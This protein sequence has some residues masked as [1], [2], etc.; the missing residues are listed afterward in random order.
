MIYNVLEYLEKTVSKFPDKT[1]IISGDTRI[2]FNEFLK[3]SRKI[4]FYIHKKVQVT[5]RPI[6]VA[7][8]RSEKTIISFMAVL[9]SGNYYVPIDV[10]TPQERLNDICSQLDPLAFIHFNMDSIIDDIKK[11]TETT[12]FTYDELASLPDLTEQENNLICTVRNKILD[13]DPCYIIF[14]SGSTGMPKGVVISHKMLIDLTE[15]LNSVTNITEEDVIGNQTP[16]FF[17][18]SIKDIYQMLKTG[19]TLS[20]IKP[21]SFVF[22][23]QLLDMMNEQKISVIMWAASAITMVANSGILDYE[24]PQYLRL[25]TFAGEQLHT[26]HLNIWRNAV[27]DVRFINLYGPTEAT[28]DCLYYEVNR[29][30]SNEEIIPLGKACFNKEVFLVNENNEVIEDGVGEL[31]VR[32]TGVGLGYYGDD[33]KTNAVYIQNPKHNLYRDIVYKT[34]DMAYINEDGDFVFA[35]RRDNQIKLFGH[36]IELGEIEVAMSALEN[37]EQNA[38]VYDSNNEILVAYYTGQEITKR[39]MNL[40][41]AKRIPKYMIPSKYVHLEEMPMTPNGKIDKKSL[42]DNL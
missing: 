39:E 23:K 8:D 42:K 4:G 34:G 21:S 10:S 25:I 2:S 38:V 9:Y 12:L 36:R 5:N 7:A 18:A 11:N 6:L 26:K 13:S 35:S 19:A 40:A 14:T 20:I 3:L 1:A 28:C 15:W 16:F 41:L 17:D 24:K 37:V 33:E 29:E 22:T 32:G 31:V 27:N 30:F